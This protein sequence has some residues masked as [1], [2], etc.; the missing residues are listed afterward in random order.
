MVEIQRTVGAE[1][2]I[3]AEGRDIGSVVFPEAEVKI[4]LDAD[5]TTRAER[6]KRELNGKGTPV[7][8]GKVY[9]LLTRG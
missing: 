9:R 6:R 5:L 2:G 3:V 1:G 8:L 4:Y 7:E